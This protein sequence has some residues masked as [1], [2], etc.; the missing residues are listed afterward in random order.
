MPE[1]PVFGS[2]YACHQAFAVLPWQI[3]GFGLCWL[4]LVCHAA[5]VALKL[6]SAGEA[7][8]AGK[9]V[10]FAG[11]LGGSCGDL[12]RSK[13]TIVC[14]LQQPGEFPK[15]EAVKDQD[16]LCAEGFGPQAGKPFR[17]ALDVFTERDLIKSRFLNR[18][19]AVKTVT[20]DF[21][22]PVKFFWVDDNKVSYDV[23][24]KNCQLFGSDG[25][26]YLLLTSKDG[27][28]ITLEISVSD[29]RNKVSSGHLSVISFV[30]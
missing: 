16:R 27:E 18:I 24:A 11:K 7:E 10:G 30:A 12:A 17:G 2:G 4:Q 26:K 15:R 29:L 14:P 8:G 20:V 5:A 23:T 19:G 21:I 25:K 9:F 6:A 28:P 22:V 13:S 3:G 1:Y